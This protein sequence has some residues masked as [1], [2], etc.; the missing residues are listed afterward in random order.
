MALKS[1]QKARFSDDASSM[2]NSIIRFVTRADEELP[3]Y[4]ADTR[5]RDSVLQKLWRSESLLSGVVSSAVSRDKN[6]GWTL[7][8]TARQT[9]YYS[10]RMHLVH[11]GLGWR[12]FLST[13][14]TE[15]YT[16]NLGYV[17]EIGFR[18]SENAETMWNMDSTRMKL[19][20][21]LTTPIIY[22]PRNQSQIPFKR[23]MYIHGN[24]MPAFEENLNYAGFCALERCLLFSKL[25]IGIFQHQLEKIGVNPPRGFLHGSG[26]ARNEWKQAVA[27]YREDKLNGDA[28]FYPGVMGIFTRDPNAKIDLIGLSQLPDNF[29]LKSFVDI[30]MQGYALAFGF[31]VGEFW[32]IESG[33]FGRTGELNIQQEQA[34]AKGE[35]DFALSFQEQLQTYFLPPSLAFSFDQRNDKGQQLKSEIDGK[36]AKMIIDLYMAGFKHQAI[37]QTPNETKD[38]DGDG[39]TEEVRALEKEAEKQE[40]SLIT[41]DEARALLANIGI[42]PQAWA[43]GSAQTDED[44]TD[45][46]EV[47]EK[48]LANYNLRRVIKL[49][50]NEP[51]VQYKWNSE[52]EDGRNYR[53]EDSLTDYEWM[54]GETQVIFKSGEDYLKKRIF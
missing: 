26:F 12:Q 29:E 39:L 53:V 3:P 33:S 5:R 48:A 24:S 16:T 27:Q 13:N 47:R 43:N 8:G 17:S 45:L 35:L 2:V 31:P 34:F 32:S 25:M 38:A 20:N 30:L 1:K 10:K 44:V 11:E 15:W 41:R 42:I 4:I 9:S 6:R 21:S 50:P 52:D 28:E 54:P 40:T 7:T 37:E 36:K 51:V 18:N 19:T 23:W 22:Y 14:A 49:F 46:Q